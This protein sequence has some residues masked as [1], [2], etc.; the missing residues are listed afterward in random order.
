[1]RKVLISVQVKA[2]DGDVLHL[3]SDNRQVNVFMFPL[4]NVIYEK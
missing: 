3:K 2:G 1:M 4:R